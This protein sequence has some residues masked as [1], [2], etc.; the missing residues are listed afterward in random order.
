VEAALLAV[1]EGGDA[2]GDDDGLAVAVD[3]AFGQQAGQVQGLAEAAAPAG[4]GGEAQEVG[5]G[6]GAD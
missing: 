6:A 4:G 1:V 3:Q 5:D 2:L